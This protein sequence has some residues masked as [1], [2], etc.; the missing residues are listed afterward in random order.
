MAIWCGRGAQPLAANQVS[1]TRGSVSPAAAVRVVSERIP[2]KWLSRLVIRNTADFAAA[3]LEPISDGCFEMQ[4]NPLTACPPYVTTR[5][6][7]GT[8]S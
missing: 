5:V 2:I 4:A 1:K 8:F 6:N 3:G 7:Y